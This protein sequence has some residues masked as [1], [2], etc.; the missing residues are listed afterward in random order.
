MTDSWRRILAESSGVLPALLRKTLDA[1]L[2]AALDAI[3]TRDT[4]G[5]AF[6]AH[7]LKG[8]ARLLG[9][10]HATSLCASLEET[11]QA[12]DAALARLLLMRTRRAF[13]SAMRRLDPP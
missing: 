12:G 5:L 2:R 3:E 7:R 10:A 8:S 6:I 1:D 4:V 9:D 13:D 11:A